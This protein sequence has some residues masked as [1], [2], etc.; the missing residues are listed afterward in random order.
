MSQFFNSSLLYNC[1]LIYLFCCI[2]KTITLNSL[3]RHAY[4]KTITSINDSITMPKGC[5]PTGKKEEDKTP[6]TQ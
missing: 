1:D 5:R 2:K 3:H 4:K 6:R